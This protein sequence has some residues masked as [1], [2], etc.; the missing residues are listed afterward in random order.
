MTPPLSHSR[1]LL[2]WACLIGCIAIGFG[3]N[4]ILRPENALTWFELYFPEKSQFD[5]EFLNL[6]MPIYG[7]RNIFIGMSIMVAA[8]YQHAKILGANVLGMGIIA[9][10]DGL[11]CYRRGT[12]SEHH[13]GYAPQLVILGFLLLGVLDRRT[14]LDREKTE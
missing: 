14:P 9:F 3:I 2:A 10:I 7:A 11:A 8:Y 4:G 12:G 6:I 13:W 1:F 5:E